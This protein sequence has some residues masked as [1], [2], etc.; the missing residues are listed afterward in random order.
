MPYTCADAVD[1]RCYTDVLVQ[2]AG[3]NAIN[4]F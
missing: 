2:N 1:V 3:A 4:V